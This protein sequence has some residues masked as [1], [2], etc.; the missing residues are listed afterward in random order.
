MLL[1]MFVIYD[2]R[3]AYDLHRRDEDKRAI[4]E[5]KRAIVGMFRGTNEHVRALQALVGGPIEPATFFG[6]IGRF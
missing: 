5:H 3:I 4:E 1:R 6:A 2:R